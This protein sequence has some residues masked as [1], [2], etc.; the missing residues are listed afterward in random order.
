MENDIL[1]DIKDILEVHFA[2][3]TDEFKKSHRDM[4]QLQKTVDLLYKE[5]EIMEDTQGSI[6]SFKELSIHNRNHQDNAIKGV[7]TDINQV[8]EA[9]ELKIDE[10]KN[11]MDD[12]TVIVK[13]KGLFDMIKK[14]LGMKDEQG[15]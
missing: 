7:K 11:I 4:D 5:R 3:M 10:V 8:K 9:V 12:H 13:K 15:G 2:K 14:M 6:Q 1:K